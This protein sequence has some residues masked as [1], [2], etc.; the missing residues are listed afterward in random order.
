MNMACTL[1]K[2]TPQEAMLGATLNAAC[3]LGMQHE[4]GSLSVGKNADLALWDIERPADLSYA[5]GQNPCVAVVK[6][7]KTVTKM[8]RWA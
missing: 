5:M 2:L 4:I 8:Q 6:H 3:A 7:G 1:F